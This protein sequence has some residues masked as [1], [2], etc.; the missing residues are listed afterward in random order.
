[1]HLG[2]F[3]AFFATIVL[4]LQLCLNKNWNLSISAEHLNWNSQTH[5]V[6]IWQKMRKNPL[7]WTWNE[8]TCTKENL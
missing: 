4:G 5:E 3:Q 6:K 7:K 2:Y 8:C 1:M